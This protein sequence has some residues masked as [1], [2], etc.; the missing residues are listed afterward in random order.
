MTDKI[1][2]SLAALQRY[3]C[4]EITGMYRMEQLTPIWLRYDDVARAW[5]QREAAL[6]KCLNQ[7]VKIFDAKDSTLTEEVKAIE[8][9]RTLLGYSHE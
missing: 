8:R 9:A 7:I 4:A 5:S 1:P 3:S 2:P 6:Q